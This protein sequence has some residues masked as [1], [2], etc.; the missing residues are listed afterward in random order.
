M[1]FCSFDKIFL[2]EEMFNMNVMTELW[3]QR[4]TFQ[5]PHI[6]A[7]W[8][9]GLWCVILT[10]TLTTTLTLTLIITMTLIT[11]LHGNKNRGL[12]LMFE[13]C[14]CWVPGPGGYPVK[15]SDF[16][17]LWANGLALKRAFWFLRS[18]FRRPT[19]TGPE[20]TSGLKL[21]GACGPCGAPSTWTLPNMCRRGAESCRTAVGASFWLSSTGFLCSVCAHQGEE[22][23]QSYADAR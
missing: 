5:A 4:P 12:S 17:F 15:R 20:C 19:G 22:G 10:L 13:E 21:G 18:E 9:F 16:D 1:L 11:T 7:H 8:I 2:I 3:T 6:F 14:P 23:R